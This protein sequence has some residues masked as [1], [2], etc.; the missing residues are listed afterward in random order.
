MSDESEYQK[1]LNELWNLIRN[2]TQV[3][4]EQIINNLD[5]KTI[6]ALRTLKN[7]YKKPIVEG[8]RSRFLAFN[9]INMREKYCRRFAMTGLI[10]F[11]YRMLSE[12]TPDDAEKY[13][14]ENDPKFA[15]KYNDQIRNLLNKKPIELLFNKLDSLKKDITNET[16]KKKIKEMVR[17][18]FVIRAKIIKYNIYL[19]RTDRSK[20]DNPKMN[21]EKDIRTME[22][23]INTHNDRLNNTQIKLDKR[24]KY[25]ENKKEPKSDQKSDQKSDK[26]TTKKQTVL[27]KEKETKNPLQEL[28]YDEIKKRNVES[29]KKE[30]ENIKIIIDKTRKELIEKNEEYKKLMDKFDEYT[31]RI[32]DF[33]IKFKDLKDEYLAKFDKK[34]NIKRI[35]LLEDVEIEKYEPTEDELNEIA[36]NVKKELNIELT[37]EEYS[38]KMQ[39]D[40]Q[41]FL[42]KYL[43]YNPDNHVKSAYKPNY[44]DPTRKLLTNNET[45]IER[46]VIPP[47]DTF[48]RLDR[49]IENNYEELR[50]A[51]DDIYCEKSDFEFDLVPLEVFEGSQEEAMEQFNA[52]KR[53]YA[54]EFETDVFLARFANHNL[55]SPFYQNREVRDFYTEKT[56]IIK[57]II[58]QNKEDARLGKKLMSERPKKGKNIKKE[59]EAAFNKYKKAVGKSELEEHGAVP[60]STLQ[61]E[62]KEEEI[63]RDLDEANEKEVEVGVHIIKPKKLGRRMI[64]FSANFN[65]NIPSIE[66]DKDTVKVQNASEFQQKILTQE[67]KI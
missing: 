40:I 14:S 5:E 7:P 53:K 3:K 52:Y 59:E 17:E 41:Q 10:G 46:S 34:K 20:L 48:F 28:T 8:N 55:L 67:S 42:D 24:N 49:Y 62:V 6:E 47:D 36:D 61:E 37:A 22:S 60:M 18:T 13:I 39:S 31:S 2:S 26:K 1:S 29:Y 4:R 25:D 33:S 32:N 58:E 66:V 50:Q 23:S 56:E 45:K 16:D 64:G 63:P 15:E 27:D 9:V 12:Y 35:D 57:R 54:D 65:F 38:E 44:E 11:I 21:I 43:K 19:L 51:T 30:I